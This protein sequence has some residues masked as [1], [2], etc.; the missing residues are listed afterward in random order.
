MPPL[1]ALSAICLPGEVNWSRHGDK[2]RMLNPA[3]DSALPL[4]VQS[5]GTRVRKAAETLRVETD[6]GST[7]VPLIDVSE[8][9]LYGWVRGA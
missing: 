4:H 2:P 1:R 9:A 7:A 5:P 8:V 6:D 3:D